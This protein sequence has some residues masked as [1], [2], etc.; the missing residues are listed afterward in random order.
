MDAATLRLILIVVGAAFLIGLYLWERRR[1]EDR[2]EDHDWDNYLGDKREPNLGALEPDDRAP[3]L[4]DYDERGYESESG[5]ISESPRASTHTRGRDTSSDSERD[6]VESEQGARERAVVGDG[7]DADEFAD[8]PP[9]ESASGSLQA[10]PSVAGQ[11]TLL[12]QLFVVAV[13][14]PFIGER[15]LVAAERV[16]LLP[17]S[18]DIFHRQAAEDSVRAPL[19]SMANMVKPGS[20]PLDAMEDFETPG[21]ALFTQLTGAPSD[22]M[23]YDELLHAARMLAEDL[24][25]DVQ[26]R[27]RRTLTA[28]RAGILRGQ[29]SALLQGEPGHPGGE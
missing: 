7:G 27:G 23:V 29:V 25:G 6:D 15:V 4:D 5:P 12:V 3:E 18:M 28:E 22:L 24:G 20:F 1:A 17:G 21:L 2:D 8:D 16:K 19:F 13:D 11:D 9:A 14:K 10:G 26:E